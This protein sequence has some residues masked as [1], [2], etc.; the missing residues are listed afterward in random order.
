MRWNVTFDTKASVLQKFSQFSKEHQHHGNVVWGHFHCLSWGDSWRRQVQKFYKI[1]GQFW[2]TFSDVTT[3]IIGD[4]P[5]R[6]SGRMIFAKF[7]KILLRN[8]TTQHEL[9]RCCPPGGRMISDVYSS[10]MQGKVNF[11]VST[12]GYPRRD[13]ETDN[14]TKAIV[15]PRICHFTINWYS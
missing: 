7:Y 3:T 6:P 8:K 13:D 4:R 1:W 10:Y 11:E 15:E 2:C 14:L 9:L 5:G 12:C